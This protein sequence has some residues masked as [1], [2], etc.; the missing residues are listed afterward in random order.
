MPI[1]NKF[2]LDDHYFY[3]LAFHT[4]F[5]DKDHGDMPSI[6]GC[7]WHND[8]QSCVIEVGTDLDVNIQSIE[9]VIRKLLSLVASKVAEN[10]TKE[11]AYST[12]L[13]STKLHDTLDIDVL[14]DKHYCDYVNKYLSETDG[15]PLEDFEPWVPLCGRLHSHSDYGYSI[16]INRQ[17]EDNAVSVVLVSGYFEAIDLPEP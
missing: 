10:D 11:V 9:R 12:G 14:I 5:E 15:V 4:H 13:R 6:E 1:F 7:T 17:G 8:I 2:Q 3:S 16:T